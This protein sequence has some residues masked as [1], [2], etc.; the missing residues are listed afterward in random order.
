MAIVSELQSRVAVGSSGFIGAPSR[1][2]GASALS[3]AT[4]QRVSA[5]LIRSNRASRACSTTHPFSAWMGQRI[6][7]SGKDID[8]RSAADLAL[9]AKADFAMLPSAGIG[10]K[11]LILLIFLD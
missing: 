8:P 3:T 2:V 11:L 5:S 1:L 9:S 6:L 7:P 10:L 4:Q